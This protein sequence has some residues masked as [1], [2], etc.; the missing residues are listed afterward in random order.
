MGEYFDGDHFVGDMFTQ[1]F[2]QLPIC[3]GFAA[4]TRCF[5]PG[6][7]VSGLWRGSGFFPN[8]G[9]ENANH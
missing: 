9:F 2:A 8:P 7:S 5:D 6:E 4:G 3:V 1:P